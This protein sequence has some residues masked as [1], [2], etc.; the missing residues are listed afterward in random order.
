MNTPTAVEHITMAVS[1]RKAWLYRLD[2]SNLSAYNPATS[3][4]QRVENG[5]G[6]GGDLGVGARYEFVLSTPHGSHPVTLSITDAVEGELVAASMQSG[7]SATETFVVQ[8]VDEGHCAAT[9]TLWLELP[10]GLDE[11]TVAA[12]SSSGRLQIR[13][14]LD[15]MKTNLESAPS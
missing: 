5:A 14:E 3:D 10:E 7:M 8:A 2:F 1:A 11:K 9:L 6:V 12:L 13:D 4:I 15:R